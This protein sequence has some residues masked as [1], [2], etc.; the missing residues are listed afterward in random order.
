MQLGRGLRLPRLRRAVR[1]ASTPTN[2][3]CELGRLRLHADPSCEIMPAADDADA[4]PERP[5]ARRAAGSLR[6]REDHPQRPRS[7]SAQRPR[8]ITRGV[9]PNEHCSH[10]LVLLRGVRLGKNPDL[11]QLDEWDAHPNAP[12]RT[13]SRTERARVDDTQ[14]SLELVSVVDRTSEI[15]IRMAAGA[16]RSDISLQLNIEAA[17]VCGAGGVLGV[18]LGLGAALALRSLGMPVSLSAPPAIAAFACACATGLVFGY[19]PARKASRWIP[20]RL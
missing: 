12:E 14:A 19:L 15:G 2:G 4:C 18:A 1:V 7:R 3:R 13:R 16:R 11:P 17:V 5:V 10:D 9:D 20:R 6:G 8:L